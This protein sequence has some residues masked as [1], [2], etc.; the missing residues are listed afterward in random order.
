MIDRPLPTR[1]RAIL[2]CAVSVFGALVCA[3]LLTVAVLTPA[4]AAALPFI[5]FICIGAPIVASWELAPAVYALRGA[6]GAVNELRES[7]DRLPET[8]HPLG[9]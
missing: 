8:P 1:Q 2:V 3:G 5:A 6:T 4:P 7:L 9:L